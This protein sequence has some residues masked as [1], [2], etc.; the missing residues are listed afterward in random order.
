M[1]QE[2]Q[3]IEKV[4]VGLWVQTLRDVVFRAGGF[5]AAGPLPRLSNRKA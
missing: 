3:D 1:K 5:G 4:V 2:N